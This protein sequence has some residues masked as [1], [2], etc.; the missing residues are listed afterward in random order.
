MTTSKEI[1]IKRY[2]RGSTGTMPEFWEKIWQHSPTTMKALAAQ[3]DPRLVRECSRH[4]PPKAKLLEGGCGSGVYLA[5]FA[6]MGYQ[7]VGVDFAQRTVAR[8]KTAL[9]DLDIQVGDIRNLPF[10]NNTFDAYY[11]GGVIEHFEDGLMPQIKEAY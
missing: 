2:L 6:E 9:P 8:L 11:S 3:A 7:V 5:R 10:Q 4:L 1:V